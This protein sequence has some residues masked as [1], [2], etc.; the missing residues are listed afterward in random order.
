[1]C[2]LFVNYRKSCCAEITKSL[3]CF[4]HLAINMQCLDCTCGVIIL[5]AIGCHFRRLIKNSN[6]VHSTEHLSACDICYNNIDLCYT[7]SILS[8]YYVKL[9][10]HP[11]RL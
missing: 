9:I 6:V 1:M 8:K 2:F 10:R 11:S 7:S 3:F 5:S 4:E